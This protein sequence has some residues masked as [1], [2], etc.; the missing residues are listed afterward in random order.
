MIARQVRVR[1]EMP[2]AGTGPARLLYRRED[3]YAVEV[4]LFDGTQSVVW[5]FGRE[6]L[7][8]GLSEPAGLADVRVW[9]DG[10]RLM[11]RL[12]SPDGCASFSADAATI[13]GFL[14]ETYQVVPLGAEAVDFSGLG[15][16]LDGAS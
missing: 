16:L 14:A 2:D 4:T 11:V 5:V 13:R 10:E 8:R 6:L 1:W 9:P 3:P 7:E 15:R 12:E